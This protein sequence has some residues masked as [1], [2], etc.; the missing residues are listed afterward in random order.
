MFTWIYQIDI[1]LYWPLSSVRYCIRLVLRWL[2]FIDPTRLYALLV[3]SEVLTV[4]FP[5][6]YD[7]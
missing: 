5:T 1:P 2:Y 3:Q 7:V 4:L 6:E